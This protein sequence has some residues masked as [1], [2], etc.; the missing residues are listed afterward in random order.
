MDGQV[1]DTKLQIT[2]ITQSELSNPMDDHSVIHL[3]RETFPNELVQQVLV[4]LQKRLTRMA[5][6]TEQLRLSQQA[7]PHPTQIREVL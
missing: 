1:L 4:L 3:R 6:S 2:S 5:L 7:P